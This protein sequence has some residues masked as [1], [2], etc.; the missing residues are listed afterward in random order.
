MLVLR[1][2]QLVL[3]VQNLPLVSSHGN[4]A[5]SGYECVFN[6]YGTKLHTSVTRIDRIDASNTTLHCETPPAKQLP[7]FP[8][9]KGDGPQSSFYSNWSFHS[10]FDGSPSLVGNRG[11]MAIVQRENII[12]TLLVFCF[13]TYLFTYLLW[14]QVVVCLICI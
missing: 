1:T 2:L 14:V 12:R 9:G 8:A 10:D 5:T 6:G 4:P 7:L 11:A 3:T 13:T